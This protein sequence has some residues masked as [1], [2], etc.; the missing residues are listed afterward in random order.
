MKPALLFMKEGPR[1]HWITVS[2][3]HADVL[4]TYWCYCFIRKPSIWSCILAAES[5][6]FTMIDLKSNRASGLVREKETENLKKTKA[7]L[8]WSH[9]WWLCFTVNLLFAALSLVEAAKAWGLWMSIFTVFDLNI[10]QNP[11]NTCKKMSPFLSQS[12]TA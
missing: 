11:Q 5:L 1:V 10:N 4:S 9:F 6:S 2:H 3:L 8:S 12:V 7:F